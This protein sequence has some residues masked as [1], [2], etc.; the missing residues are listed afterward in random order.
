MKTKASVFVLAVV[1]ASQVG[2]TDCGQIISDPGFDLWCGD[3]L[4]VWKLERGNVAEVPTWNEGDPGVQLL[5]SNTA[6]EQLTSVT[7]TDTSCIAF[8]LLSNIDLESQVVLN[9]DVNGDGSVEKSFQLPTTAWK[10]VQ[11]LVAIQGV[12]AGVRFELAKTGDGSAVLAD[13]DAE[14]STACDASLPAIVPGPAPLGAPCLGSDTCA[15]GICDLPAPNLPGNGVSWFGIGNCG[16]C[17][18]SSCGSGQAC[19]VGPAFS[20]VEAV[21]L[22]CVAAASK[23]FGALCAVDDEC[24]TGICTAGACSTCRDPDHACTAGIACAQEYSTTL[25]QYAPFLCG[26]GSK[27]AGSGAACSSGDD[28]A[29]GVCNGTAYS[30][31]FDGRPCTS[32][33]DC[34]ADDQLASGDC[35]VSGVLGGTCE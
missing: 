23:P 26:P 32:E 34:V 17:D 21:P 31:C 20:P 25:V 19:G 10:P 30:Q 14:V 16:G 13:I 8:T 33:S 35:T 18:G 6:I 4:C 2:A 28:C 7:S 27:T 11:L 15:S 5:G 9:V 12:Y 29:S 1:A 22:V 24:V 3:S